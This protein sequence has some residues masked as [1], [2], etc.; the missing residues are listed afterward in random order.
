[1]NNAHLLSLDKYFRKCSRCCKYPH[2]V[3]TGHTQRGTW[4]HV[5]VTSSQ[6]QYSRL[7]RCEAVSLG[8]R[9]VPKIQTASRQD[10]FSLQQ[11]RGKNLKSRIKNLIPCVLKL[12]GT[13]RRETIWTSGNENH[14]SAKKNRHV[15]DDYF[16]EHMKILHGQ[17]RCYLQA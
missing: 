2:T 16:R 11:H 8:G 3:N 4:A 10:D 5:G 12:Q 6:F 9:A 1:M 7:L 14:I 17:L 15:T 13:L